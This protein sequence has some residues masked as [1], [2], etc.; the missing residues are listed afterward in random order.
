MVPLLFALGV[1]IWI[2]GVEVYRSPEMP[3]GDPAWNSAAT[4]HESSNGAVPVYEYEDISTLGI[5]A[6]QNGQ[7]VLSIG[8]WNIGLGSSDLV[9]VPELSINWPLDVTRGPYVQLGTPDSMVI[10]WRTSVPVDSR[11]EY[12]SAPGSLTG[13]AADSTPTTEHEITVTGLTPDT[14]YYYAVGTSSQMLAGGDATCYFVT[15]PATGTARPMRFWVVGGVSG[16]PLGSVLC[17]F[18]F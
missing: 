2:N 17:R 7:N 18:F 4:S 16:L 11:V 6:L 8:V 14:R 9:L 12:G 1:V 5:P 10:R 3:S 13:A 15:S